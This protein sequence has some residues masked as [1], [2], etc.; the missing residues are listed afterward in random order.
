MCVISADGMR[1]CEKPSRHSLAWDT[2]VL[3][4]LGSMMY[5]NRVHESLTRS[6]GHTI[7]TNFCWLGIRAAT[8]VALLRL[9]DR[10]L[11]IV[12]ILTM[13]LNDRIVHVRE[14]PM[15]G[16]E[17]SPRRPDFSA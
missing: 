9:Y 13:L 3:Y 14:N 15:L 16:V 2:C 17:A 12:A 1:A 10:V 8:C 11:V 6:A 5:V 7:N 4:L